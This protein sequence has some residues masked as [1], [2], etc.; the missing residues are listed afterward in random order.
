[1]TG[2]YLL[3][4]FKGFRKTMNGLFSISCKNKNSALLL[5]WKTESSR[6]EVCVFINWLYKTL[7]CFCYHSRE[8]NKNCVWGNS[9][10]P[11]KIFLFS[12]INLPAELWRP[13]NLIARITLITK[14]QSWLASPIACFFVIIKVREL[15]LN[16]AEWVNEAVFWWVLKWHWN[17]LLALVQNQFSLF[18]V[19]KY[20]IMIRWQRS[21]N[22]V[23]VELNFELYKW[24][25]QRSWRIII[26]RTRTRW[27][28]WQKINHTD[29]NKSRYERD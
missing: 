2:Y 23:S 8:E 25:F 10:L 6:Y 28:V 9:E 16:S 4:N 3:E 22:L 14:T 21:I 27:S 17:I 11:F 5:S 24:Y 26:I 15:F 1:M 19:F 29:R 13:Y 18:F 20:F 12:E 7:C